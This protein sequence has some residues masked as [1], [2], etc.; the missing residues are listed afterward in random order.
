MTKRFTLKNLTQHIAKMYNKECPTHY[1]EHEVVKI[2]AALIEMFRLDHTHIIEV[3]IDDITII[4][5]DWTITLKWWL[6]ECENS[7]ESDPVVSEHMIDNLNM[8]YDVFL[9]FSE[10]Y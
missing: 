4:H 1:A 9:L 7:L 8:L 2:R 10:N 5:N 6:Q 3:E